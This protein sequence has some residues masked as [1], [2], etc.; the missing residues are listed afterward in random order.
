M[1]HHF[2][3]IYLEENAYFTKIWILCQIIKEDIISVIQRLCFD[4]IM[5]NGSSNK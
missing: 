1:N 5:V 3:I 4:E 2:A